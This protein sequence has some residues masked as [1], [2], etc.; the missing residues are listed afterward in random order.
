MEVPIPNFYFMA[1]QFVHLLALTLWVGGLV[2]A[3]MI[4]APVLF[5]RLSS[6]KL[7]GEIFG[8]VVRRFE[9]LI[10][11]CIVAL[12]GTGIVKYLTWENL[13][14][15]NSTRYAAIAVMSVCGIY[16]A[17]GLSPRL[18]ALQ[19]QIGEAPGA[20]AAT[21]KEAVFERLHRR[22][23]QCMVISLVCGLIVLLL[24]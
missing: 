7:A 13:T 23:F 24:A 15:W 5:S 18:M 2:M 22:S 21:E 14:P 1:V 19:R 16:S 3:G 9:R 4:T 10:L 17:W 12:I 20:S 6:R 8:E 11:I